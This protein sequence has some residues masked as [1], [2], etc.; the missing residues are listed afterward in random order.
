[1]PTPASAAC[2]QRQAVDP[3]T[4]SVTDTSIS[5]TAGDGPPFIT[6]IGTIKNPSDMPI[7]NVVVEVKY[8][9][10]SNELIDVVTEP[11]YGVVVPASNE[12]AF[13]V[14]DVADKPE[15]AYVSHSVRIVS[16]EHRANQ[17]S[18]AKPSSA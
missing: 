17:R 13:R 2:G 10:A 4:V 12:V 14:R 8:F 18:Q 11:I 7:E 15:T 1:M 6:T 9:N 16:A 5:Y 3:E